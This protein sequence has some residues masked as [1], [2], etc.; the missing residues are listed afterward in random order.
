[1]IESPLVDSGFTIYVFSPR[2]DPI[3][4]LN[5]SIAFLVVVA[6]LRGNNVSGQVKVVKCY[7]YQSEG[8]MARQCTQPKR[9][10]N[11]AWYKDKAMLAEAQ[12]T[13]QILDEE[14]L[15]FLADPRVLDG[16]APQ[17]IIPN[18]VAFQTKDLDTYDSHCDD[19]L[20]A[21]VVL[22]ANISIYGSDVILE[23]NV[24]D[25]NL[26]V[27][28]D[29]VILFVIEQ[30]L[31]QMINHVNK[32]EKPN[33]E[34][35]NESITA[36]LE[37]YREQVKTF[38]QCLNI[39]LSSREKMIDSQ[40][41]NM[42][43]E[44][45]SLK[46]QVDSLE[47]NLSKQIKEKESLLQTLTD[48]GKRFVSQQELSADEAFWYHMLNPSTK[49]SNAL[50]VKIDAPKELS[51]VSLVNESLKKLK[52]HLANFD[53]VVKIRTTPNART[54]GMFKL[55]LD[56]LAPKLLQNREAHID[57]LRGSNATDIPLSSSLVMTACYT[58]NRSLISLRYNKTPYEIIQDKKLDLSFFH[59]FGSL[60]YPTIDN[61]DLGKL[62]AK[63]DIGIFVGYVSAKKAFRIYN[64]RTQK[65]IQTIHV[66]FD[67]L[68]A[69]ASEELGSGPELQ[70]ITPATSSSGLVPNTVSQQPCIS[71]KRDDWDRL[72]QPMFDEYFNPPSIAVS[73]VQ[74][75]AALRAMVLADSFVPTSIDQDALST[76]AVD[77]PLFTR[78][79]GNDLLRVRFLR[80]K[81]KAPQAIIKCIKNIQDTGMSLTAYADADHVGCQDTRR[82]T[83]GRAQF[84]GDKLVSWSSKKQKSIVISSTKAK[85]IALSW[86]CAQILWMRSQLTD[87]GFQFN[88]I[89]LYRNNK[90]V[91]ALYCNNVQHSRAKHI[92]I[93]LPNQKARYEKHVFRNIETSGRGNGRVIMFKKPASPQL[94]TVPVSPE[95]P[96]K[97]SGSGTVIK[98]APSAAKIK[99]SITNEGTGIKPRV[100]DMTEEVSTESEPE[101]WRKDEDDNNNE[102]ES[103]S[104]ESDQERHPI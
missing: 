29:S 102:H 84:L 37:R 38:K 76:S 93:Y 50:T 60:C 22:M 97:K 39:D 16:Q 42:I 65:I 80:T 87:Y 35:N 95:E 66:T 59:V 21:K 17:T 24:Q 25:T 44:K 30:M 68:I 9:P 53:K 6:S 77:P 81:D 8:H 89:P 103:R 83:S 63:D 2:V 43:K 88:K 57:Y 49:S 62:N 7:N 19:I 100:S 67:E 64:K 11:A 75:A 70:C 72:F 13:G 56:P 101:S 55:D 23:A 90:S 79:A 51:N 36:E 20:N 96:T 48:F 58:Q 41:D 54:E 71:P 27:Q 74:E 61:D 15:A 82:N 10:R 47:Q 32:W 34:Q 33:K 5:K 46:E 4:C 98:T 78:K 99:P 12:E 40:M 1:M 69:M 31:E 52:L 94:T 45:L 91:I 104:K 3:A 14:Q 85:Y 73:L 26:Q 86:C 28:Q 92:D 18:N